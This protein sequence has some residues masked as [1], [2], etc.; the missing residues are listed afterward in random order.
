MTAAQRRDC[1][2]S[3][4]WTQRGLARQLCADDRTVRRWFAGA[5]MPLDIEEW[6]QRRAIAA[7]LDPPP[8]H[9]GGAK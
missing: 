6:L 7:R 5:E 9:E 4:G 3:L 8:I 1:L 2:T